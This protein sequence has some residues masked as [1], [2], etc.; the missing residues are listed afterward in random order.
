[1]IRYHQVKIHGPQFFSRATRSKFVST[2]F[3]KRDYAFR[4][5]WVR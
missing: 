4:R 2:N 3:E 1:L 5:R